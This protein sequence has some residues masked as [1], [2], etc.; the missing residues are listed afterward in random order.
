MSD[1]SV[2]VPIRPAGLAEQQVFCGKFRQLKRSF[3]G[4]LAGRPPQLGPMRTFWV[5]GNGR[6]VTLRLFGALPLKLAHLADV[7]VPALAVRAAYIHAGFLAALWTCLS[8][9]VGSLVCEGLPRSAAY[10]VQVR[11]QQSSSI[12]FPPPN[13]GKGDSISNFL[14]M[15]DN[16]PSTDIA[17]CAM[18]WFS[19]KPPPPSPLLSSPPVI[20]SEPR[21]ARLV[22]PGF[23]DSDPRKILHTLLGA[24]GLT[25]IW[26]SQRSLEDLLGDLVRAAPALG[27]SRPHGQ[28]IA[29]FNSDPKTY[30]T[31]LDGAE[32]SAVAVI[33][34]PESNSGFLI[35]E[36]TMPTQRASLGG[37]AS[38]IIHTGETT[39]PIARLVQAASVVPPWETKVL[40]HIASDPFSWS[41]VPLPVRSSLGAWERIGHDL[42]VKTVSDI[43][44]DEVRVFAGIHD[45]HPSL[46]YPIAQSAE[47][48][49]SPYEAL[50]SQG[51]FRIDWL[52]PSVV[53]VRDLPDDAVLGKVDSEAEVLINEVAL[54][55]RGRRKMA[56]PAMPSVAPDGG[57]WD[58]IEAPG[59]RPARE[60]PWAGV[61]AGDFVVADRVR[62]CVAE[63]ASTFESVEQQAQ[64]LIQLRGS[65]FAHTWRRGIDDALLSPSWLTV[66]SSSYDPESGRLVLSGYPT[67]DLLG[68]S[69]AYDLGA[70]DGRNV[71]TWSSQGHTSGLHMPANHVYV[72]STHT[73]ILA[74][75]T[76]QTNACSVDYHP[77]QQLIAVLEFLGG[78]TGAVS[79]TDSNGNRRVLTTVA[80]VAGH[81]PVRFSPDG[82]WLLIS[83]SGR[84]TTL[85]EVANGRHIRVEPSNACWWPLEESTLLCVENSDGHMVPR[86][87]SLRD[88]EH[89]QDFP[90]ILVTDH[91]AEEFHSAWFP[92]VSPDGQ[93][94]MVQTIAGVTAEHQAQFGAGSRA[95]RVNLRTGAARTTQPPFLDGSGLLERDVRHHAWVGQPEPRKVDLHPSLAAQLLPGVTD[96]EYL[97]LDRWADDAQQFVVK[98]LNR[99]I[100]RIDTDEPEALM[101]EIIAA[102]VAVSQ[103]HKLWEGMSEWL[104]NVQQVTTE[105]VAEGR[106]V[107]DAAAAWTKF[108]AAKAALDAGREDLVDT[109]AAA[110]C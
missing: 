38:E 37:V 77:G 2:L 80:S 68:M 86:L 27:R 76:Y 67:H 73:R 81:E 91:L 50:A 96:H 97:S 32:G 108:G 51:C 9:I 36:L 53:V 106:I 55:L 31:C 105:C 58:R 1:R 12:L 56:M 75:L 110:R 42:Y 69:P 103:D 61:G 100:D 11:L 22:D 60:F 19:K 44:G 18:S 88:A 95:T 85:I 101:P 5:R 10:M 90:E 99:A 47:G 21:P 98:L 26:T 7:F 45:G 43:D 20:R 74:P 3:R 52:D 59:A 14:K 35:E 102:M 24:S 94:L 48:D 70:I 17:L 66:N 72:G 82:T 54:A 89:V 84:G 29:V 6:L 28:G 63:E 65:G 83:T 93:E 30:W 49:L 39:E 41:M 16:F 62:E 78:S 57:I 4:F 46:I 40:R 109:I 71:T 104:T 87:F 64:A 15:M 79:V 34:T 92:H 13:L 25:W 23:D 107:G 33:C 8:H